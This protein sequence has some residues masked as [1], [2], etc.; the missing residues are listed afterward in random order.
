MPINMP[1]CVCVY[2]VGSLPGSVRDDDASAGVESVAEGGVSK[3]EHGG[4]SRGGVGGEGV[5]G[6]RIGMGG[7]DSWVSVAPN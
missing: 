2:M 5:G 3:G 7:K 1:M 6:H 4:G